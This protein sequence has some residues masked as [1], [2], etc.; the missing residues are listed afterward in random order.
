M[1]IRLECLPQEIEPVVDLLRQNLDVVSVSRP[2]ANRG[3]SRLVRVYVE[4]SLHATAPLRAH[5]V[6]T[7]R[8]EVGLDAP[9]RIGYSSRRRRES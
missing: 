3:E 5:A 8:P 1:K 4:F 6:R 7:D 9:K 2:Y